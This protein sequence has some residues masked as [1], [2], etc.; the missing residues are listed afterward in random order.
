MQAVVR[1]RTGPHERP[2]GVDGIARV[3]AARGLVQRRKERRAVLLEML[4]D[5]RSRSGSSRQRGLAA[6][7]ADVIGQV[8]REPPVVLAKRLE[9][10]P[11][12]LA[13]RRQR[14]EIGWLIALDARRQDLGL[15][16]RRDEGRPCKPLDRIEQ[17]VQPRSPADDALPVGDE[18]SEDGGFDRF[19]LMPQLGERPA[20]DR[21]QHVR[22]A[23]FASGSAGP[24]I[25]FEQSAPVHEL[26]Q[27]RFGGRSSEPIPFG[28]RLGGE[29]RVRARVAAGEVQR[30][31]RRRLEKRLR[32]SRWQR[33]AERVA[34]P[35][36]VL[37]RDEA[38]L[39]GRS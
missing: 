22:V 18:A 37:D 36:R 26:L 5:A 28:K 10:A 29:R 14:V 8:E 13:G 39:A 12:D 23:P 35:A 38:R 24:E 34:I 32:Q 20:A 25:A 21:L 9:S 2:D 1:D 15:E 3:A 4:E 6:Q 11:H 33:H 19:D 16:N 30:G 17:R 7:F 27:Q 31:V